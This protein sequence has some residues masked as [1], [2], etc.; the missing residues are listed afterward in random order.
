MKKQNKPTVTV[1]RDKNIEIAVVQAL[2]DLN[3][4]DLTGKHVLLKPNVG[5]EVEF[6]QHAINTNPV[7][8]GAIFHYLKKHYNATY[9]IGDSPIISTDIRRAF[10]GSGYGS[11]LE[12]EGLI[13]LD[14]DDPSPIILPIPNGKIIHQI[15]VTGYWPDIDYIVSIPVLKM[16]MHTGA[17]LSFK[18][19]KGLIYKRNKI[20]LH[21]KRAPEMMAQI[22]KK[23]NF[24]KNNVKE[25]DAAIA[26]LAQVFKPDL[27]IIDAS[28]ALEGMGPSSGN[29]KKLDMIIASTDFLAA[30]ITA[31]ALTQPT[32]TLYDVPHLKIISELHEPKNLKSLEDIITIPSDLNEYITPLEGPPSSI[33]IKYNNIKLIDIESCSS[34]LSTIFN[35]IKMNKEFIDEHFTK[36]HPLSVAIGKGIC[37]SRL[38]KPTFLVGN[39]TANCKSKGIFVQGCAPVQSDIIKT[40]KKFY[41][42]N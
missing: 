2:D 33:S 11:L 37:D 41:K 35:F 38:N 17:S 22:T 26:D 5:R 10:E 40:I 20:A 6:N 42:I 32:W 13:F 3:I 14:L 25:L 16:H 36:E 12:E 1:T 24:S 7:V 19:L 34:C 15:K 31:I 30:D 23:Y 29:A 18:N 27:A 8:V 39:C 21:Q 9:Y 28:Y 4:P